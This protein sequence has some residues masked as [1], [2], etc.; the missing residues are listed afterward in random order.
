MRLA[1]M[2]TDFWELSSGEALH[3][4]HPETFHIP[5]IAAR[6][7]LKQGQAARLIFEIESEG[8]NGEVMLQGERM[9]VIVAERNGDYY[10]GI[11]DNQPASFEPSETTY[12]CFGAEIAFL[13]EHVIDIGEPPEEYSRWQLS[14]EPER[15]WPRQ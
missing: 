5:S 1:K 7:N 2:E 6:K 8:E 15:L 11:L 9:W 13:P 3:A 12:L 10:I 14:Q 4:A